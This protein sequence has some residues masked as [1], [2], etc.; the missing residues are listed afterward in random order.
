MK[1]LSVVLCTY[2][3]EKSI[4]KTLFKLLKYKIIKEIIIIDDN[5]QDNTIRLIRQIKNKKVKLYV[6]KKIRGF[7]TR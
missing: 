1:N 7:F 6:R 2:N 5:S 3:E 4:S